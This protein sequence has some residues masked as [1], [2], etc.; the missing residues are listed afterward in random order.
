MNEGLYLDN[1]LDEFYELEDEAD[2]CDLVRGMSF[3]EGIDSLMDTEYNKE[4]E[5]EDVNFS[6]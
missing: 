1:Y 3:H 5:E 2:I 6:E 4:R